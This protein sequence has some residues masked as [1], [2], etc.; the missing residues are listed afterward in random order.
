MSRFR[1]NWRCHWTGTSPAPTKARSTRSASAGMYRSEEAPVSSSSIWPPG[2]SMNLS[3]TWSRFC[4][5]TASGCLRTWMTSTSS[6]CARS[7]RPAHLQQVPRRP[8][9]FQP[10]GFLVAILEDAD[11]A[12]QANATLAEAGFAQ[13][14]LRVYTSQQILDSWQRFQAERSLAQRVA[15]AFTDD[16]DT[17]EQYFGYARAGRSALWVR[18][19]GQGRRR[20]SRARPGR[21]PGPALPPLRPRPPR[22]P[23][24][25]L[26]RVLPA[27]PGRTPSPS[28]VRPDG[29]GIG[30]PRMREE[31][32]PIPDPTSRPPPSPI[33][34]D[35]AG[36]A[37]APR[38]R[39]PVVE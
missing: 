11:Q 4:S 28:L 32:F 1:F 5:V 20:S 30:D 18:V 36:R 14:D 35:S 21:P 22:R 16:P 3:Y 8:L 34:P 23:P 15:G 31:S 19:A 2:W 12:E 33:A 7:R 37:A 17:I 26:R 38:S 27:A 6:R 25:P 39:P 29:P 9:F 13:T 24:H 10:Q